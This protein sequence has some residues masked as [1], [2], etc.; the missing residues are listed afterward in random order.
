MPNWSSLYRP[1]MPGVVQATIKPAGGLTRAVSGQ[2]WQASAGGA[3]DYID[4]SRTESRFQA[5]D[6]D[7]SGVIR[8]DRITVAATEYTVTAADHDGHGITTLHV[9]PA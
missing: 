6:S 7:L 9:E 2:W 1:G 3:T 4:L 8:G 5:P